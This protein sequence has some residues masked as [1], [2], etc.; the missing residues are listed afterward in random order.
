MAASYGRGLT[1]AAA[2]TGRAMAAL[3]LPLRV[4]LR[5]VLAA[6]A[7]L[8]LAVHPAPD[9]LAELAALAAL[10]AVLAAQVALALETAP[11]ASAAKAARVIVS[12]L[13]IPA[14]LA[15]AVRRVDRAPGALLAAVAVVGQQAAAAAGALRQRQRRRQQRLVAVPAAAPGVA[16]MAA[17]LLAD[18]HWDRSPAERR[19]HE[20]RQV[21]RQVRSSNQPCLDSARHKPGAG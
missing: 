6:S 19:W 15:P 13:A 3:L 20:W 9:R 18:R 2:Q 8:V 4:T 11:E 12:A 5:A 14:P 10:V 21:S 16:G 7:A 17:G 1:T